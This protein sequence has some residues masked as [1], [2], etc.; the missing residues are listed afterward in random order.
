M[1][2]VAVSTETAILDYLDS[3]HHGATLTVLAAELQG[4]TLDDLKAATRALYDDRAINRVSVKAP[5]GSGYFYVFYSLY[6]RTVNVYRDDRPP[7]PA[8]EPAVDLVALQ[9][10]PPVPAGPLTPDQAVDVL[11]RGGWSAEPEEVVTVERRVADRRKPRIGI[12]DVIDRWRL[13]FRL[14]RIIEI[15]G[16]ARNRK[17]TEEDAELVVRLIREHVKPADDTDVDAE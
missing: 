14:S 2:T 17:L 8:P 1:T 5:K 12:M 11:T 4:H 7:A 6:V 3:V 9:A 15:V 16:A 10:P 13:G